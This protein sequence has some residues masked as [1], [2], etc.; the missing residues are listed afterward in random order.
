MFLLLKYHCKRKM[1]NSLISIRIVS[2]SLLPFSPWQLTSNHSFV[3]QKNRIKHFE[4]VWIGWKLSYITQLSSLIIQNTW[5]PWWKCCLA[6]FF[7][8]VLVT[9]N[10]KNWVWVMKTRNTFSLFSNYGNS[11]WIM[12]T[13]IQWEWSNSAQLVGP[14]HM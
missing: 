4:G 13:E 14:T 1:E 2:N 11:F 3:L 6:K 12:E 8:L 10:S 9:Q 7:S 5:D